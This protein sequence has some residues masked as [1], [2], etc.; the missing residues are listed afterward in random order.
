M[1]ADC[2]ADQ[3]WIGYA[4]TDGV[5]ALARPA[6]A[7]H[8]ATFDA[9]EG[10]QWDGQ[11]SVVEGTTL[12]TGLGADPND[13]PENDPFAP[14]AARASVRDASE[15]YLAA[16]VAFAGRVAL[17]AGT[18]GAGEAGLEGASACGATRE[19]RAGLYYRDNTPGNAATH[20]SPR[21]LFSVIGCPVGEWDCDQAT[22]MR[23]AYGDPW[24]CGRDNTAFGIGLR[25]L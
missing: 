19:L 24:L 5:R 25:L 17:Y 10:E 12:S 14:A 18:C 20:L 1:H 4:R 23:S 16:N 6:L 22:Y 8:G 15:L 13:A 9:C 7:E 2:E 11:D 21:C 3:P